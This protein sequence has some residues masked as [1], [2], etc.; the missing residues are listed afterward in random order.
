[1]YNSTRNKNIVK[2]FLQCFL[3]DL[4]ENQGKTGTVDKTEI[5]SKEINSRII[6]SKR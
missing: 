2:K 4:D 1:M 3:E 6:K 5:E